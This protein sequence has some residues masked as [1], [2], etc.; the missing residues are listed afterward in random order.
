MAS[1]DFIFFYKFQTRLSPMR[2]GV[3][4]VCPVKRKKVPS[5]EKICFQLEKFIFPVGNM[6]LRG[7]WEFSP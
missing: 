2:N 5:W 7:Y 6:K 3:R 4:R 1:N